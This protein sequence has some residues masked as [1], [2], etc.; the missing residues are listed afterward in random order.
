MMDYTSQ[1]AASSFGSDT[2]SGSM[3][4]GR[5]PRIR[6]V[7]MVRPNHGTLP[8]PGLT[9]RHGPS[10]GFSVRGGREH[11]TGFFVSY[12]EPASEAHR[13][14]LKV[15]DQIV[16]VNGFTVEDAVHKEVLQL[17]SNHTHLTLKVRSVGM[18]PVKDKRTDPLSWQ[19]ITDYNSSTRSSPQLSDKIQDVRINIMVAPRT[20]L[21]CGICKGPEWKPG[22]FVQFTKEGGIARE[23]GLRPG[24]QIL[25][26][27][28]VDFSDIPFNEAVNLMKGARQLDLIV[29]KGAGSELFPGESSGY[30]SSASSVTGDQ[31]P[32]WSE[33]KRLSIVKEESL[34]LEDRLSQLDR[35]K[36]KKWEKIEWDDDRD[37]KSSY[38]FKPTI[39][40]LSENTSTIK[41]N[42]EE[43]QD[44]DAKA[45]NTLGRGK[46]NKI[47][48]ICLVSHQHE[49]KTVVV[50]VHRSDEK[51]KTVLAKSPSIN[52][53]NSVT[54]RSSNTSSTLSST[55]SSAICEEIQR[56]AA[57]N[58]TT[59]AAE[60]QS[61]SSPSIDEQL[62][63]RK[64]LKG[65]DS[66][67]QQ[68]HTQLMNE[69]R[70]AH[71]KMFKGAEDQDEVEEVGSAPEKASN[72]ETQGRNSPRS[73]PIVQQTI[74]ERLSSLNS[75]QRETPQEKSSTPISRKGSNASVISPPPPPPPLPIEETEEVA[76]L[77]S[78]TQPKQKSKAPPP[79][80]P[81]KV[82]PSNQ[83][84]PCP[85]PDYDTLSISST[86]TLP[87][88]SPVNGFVK[89][90]L[91]KSLS[92][93]GY[94]TSPETTESLQTS[95]KLN[96][97]NGIT[98]KNQT[99][100]LKPKS[101]S[102]SPNLQN[103]SVANGTLTKQRPVSVIIGEYPSGTS[104][105]Q[106]KKLDF[107]NNSRENA[108]RGSGNDSITSQFA[109]ELAQTLNRS[110]LRK[111][112]ESMENLLNHPQIKANSNGSVR[113]SVNNGSNLLGRHLAKSTNDLTSLDAFATTSYMSSS[114][115]AFSNRVT[116]SI[117]SHEKKSCDSATPSGI[118][119]H[120]HQHQQHHQ[121]YNGGD[122][123]TIGGVSPS[124]HRS[125][126]HH[127]KT[128][129]FGEIPTVINDKPLHVT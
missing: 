20:K 38:Q 128:I 41:V 27:N 71:R 120:H 85:T 94:A 117:P 91:S 28:N 8:P 73:E 39:I 45:G 113:I 92:H 50:E 36:T 111:K 97:Q 59:S 42:S 103:G 119:K 54:S 2:L 26:C 61:T 13:Q 65:V 11:G 86:A 53:F 16:R 55:L 104:R 68:Q 62:Q 80:V 63:M 9:C 75:N 35:F 126:L 48:D 29:R 67:K 74:N 7:R 99:N 100:Y 101:S 81:Q 108:V 102:A 70:K 93:N 43:C 30:N 47:A 6:T 129:T 37:E 125:M 19:I 12:V 95:P 89:K 76:N 82:T 107:L 10:L 124:S 79:P 96:Q 18:I 115:K 56:R 112:T 34:D 17:I 51:E 15:G 106:P 122:H 33:S 58:K 84:P 114:R 72:V 52:S 88:K 24:D 23:A 77:K 4:S 32:S 49:T 64:I 110:N 57:R 40:N 44:E 127:Q 1:Y 5:P 118:L 60:T 98:P 90:D 66:E 22:I 46:S 105:K 21:G 87:K 3:G 25:Y 31:S 14:G 109:S 123:N 83:P 116:I 78:P 121:H 69:F